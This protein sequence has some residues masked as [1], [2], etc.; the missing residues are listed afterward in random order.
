[1]KVYD[2]S[3]EVFSC[4]VYSGDPTPKKETL[5]SM[6]NGDKY[7]LTAFSMCAHN[8]THVD[9]PL[10]FIRNG[11][12][13]DALSLEHFVGEAIVTT[14][15]GEMHKADAEKIVE[16]N[17]KIDTYGAKRVLIKGN[18]VVLEDAAEVF[19]KSGILLLGVESQSVGSYNA[20]M[21]AHLELL[22][23]N[24]VILEGIDLKSVSDGIYTLCAAPLNL[25]GA[26]G[27][28]CRAILI[29]K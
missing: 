28:P 4:R 20:P 26:D 14:F 5:C 12:S 3:Q 17:E 19:A 11:K 27:S 8:G 1:M 24:V 9:A 29:E 7:N 25:K 13:V 15:N 22:S 23:N 16:R 10:H 6:E 2:I 21:K 18:A